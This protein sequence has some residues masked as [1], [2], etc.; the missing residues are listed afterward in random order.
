M[1]RVDAY[2]RELPKKEE[3]RVSLKVPSHPDPEKRQ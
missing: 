2:S 1:I 3:E